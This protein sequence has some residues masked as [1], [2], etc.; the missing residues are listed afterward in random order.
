MFLE[1]SFGREKFDVFMLDYFN[2]H[3][4]QSLGTQ[5]FI[6]Y[7]K[8]NLTHKY[9]DIVSDTMLNEWIYEQGLPSV[10]PKPTS[11]AFNIID[12]LT[13]QL[14]AEEVTLDSLDTTKWTLHEWLHFINNLP[15]D[16]NLSL[17]STLDKRFNLTSSTNAEITHAWY[18]LSIK[19]GYK[20]VYPQ[21]ATYL[22]SIGR[23]KLIVP[24]YKELAN[25]SA[26]KEWALNVYKQARP[27]YHGLAKGTIDTILKN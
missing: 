21:M 7:L 24:L 27:G 5:N 1:E 13:N 25:T 9:P 11:N 26:G 6:V 2:Y 14:L 23:R 19:V 18:L 8:E 20:H 3:A 17:M 12:N 10:A 4:F 16:V 15:L 22:K